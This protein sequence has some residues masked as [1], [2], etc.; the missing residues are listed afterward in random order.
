MIE[1]G[2]ANVMREEEMMAASNEE[3]MDEGRKR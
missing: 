3:I 2:R 1:R